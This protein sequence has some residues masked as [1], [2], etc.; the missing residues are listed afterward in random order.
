MTLG[1]SEGLQTNQAKKPDIVSAQLIGV[2]TLIFLQ[3]KL[4]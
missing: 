2:L 4:N 1:T 3:Q